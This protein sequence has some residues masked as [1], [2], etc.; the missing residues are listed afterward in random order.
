MEE[1]ESTEAGAYPAARRGGPVIAAPIA[2][3]GAP[4]LGSTSEGVVDVA[5]PHWSDPPTGQVPRVLVDQ[6]APGADDP[7]GTLAWRELD[8]DWDQDEPLAVLDLRGVEPVRAHREPPAQPGRDW[9]TRDTATRDTATQGE[10]PWAAGAGAEAA[11]PA[12]PE[13]SAPAP[14]R[15]AAAAGDWRA[16]AGQGHLRVLGVVAEAPSPLR[17]T[18]SEAARSRGLPPEASPTDV[19]DVRDR[20]P[21]GRT[22]AGGVGRIGPTETPDPAR[23]GSLLG[24]GSGAE[25]RLVDE[26]VARPSGVTGSSSGRIGAVRVVAHSPRTPAAEPAAFPRAVGRETG[27]AED[28]RGPLA[29][30]GPDRSRVPA[31]DAVDPRRRGDS[32]PS[33][34]PVSRPEPPRPA[35][36]LPVASRSSASSPP[37]RNAEASAP[38]ARRAPGVD[39]LSDLARDRPG[40][41]PGAQ[42]GAQSDD[43]RRA[44]GVVGRFPAPAPGGEPTVGDRSAREA[45][46]D[47]PP[48]SEPGPRRDARREPDA[49]GG[50]ADPAF[51]EGGVAPPR[52]SE[53]WWRRP[54]ASRGAH[55]AGGSGVLATSGDFDVRDG[56]DPRHGPAWTSNPDESM[57]PGPG[58]GSDG[59]IGSG[60]DLEA[61]EGAAVGP[62]GP[63]SAP[64]RHRTAETPPAPARD[65]AREPGESGSRE[66]RDDS[67]DASESGAPGAGRNGPGAFDFPETVAEA[68]ESA[69]VGRP[70]HEEADAS[71]AGALGNGRNPDERVGTAGRTRPTVPRPPKGREV[72]GV[73]AS[74]SASRSTPQRKRVAWA[75]VT[76]VVLGGGALA[77]FAEGPLASTVLVA[78]VLVFAAGEFYAVLRRAGYRPAALVGLVGTAAAVVAGYLRGPSGLVAVATAVT[79]LSFLW[80]LFGVSKG[81]PGPNV[82]ATLLGFAWVGGLGAFAGMVLDPRAFPHDHGVAYLLGMVIAVVA[83]DVGAYALGAWLGRHRLAPTVSPHKTWEGLVGGSVASLVVGALVVPLVHPWTFG[84]AMTVAVAVVVLAPLGDLAESMVKRDLGVK[85]MGSILPGHGGFLDRVDG[86]LFVLPALYYVLVVMVGLH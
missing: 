49:S 74:T 9:A 46:V 48:G 80:Y 61:G 18:E 21:G 60:V 50:E 78:V 8:P 54:W 57:L 62:F 63:A 29:P 75:I 59:V 43:S 85:D 71:Q 31:P 16:A 33:G 34:P 81:R 2:G 41:V 25:R 4:P 20:R 65:V 3:D 17:E 69:K 47:Q 52:A 11:R 1:S 83:N 76:G 73:A 53:S 44:P 56:A 38:D 58:T 55:R 68:L 72:G 13:P 22:P 7:P 77:A 10:V 42:S 27:G 36:T 51:G 84:L 82:G 28:R 40:R 37:G 5:L 64:S 24:E 19:V 30:G 32:E 6:A 26:I 79:V 35:E 39:P 23:A 45:E 70:V 15:P 14:T 67:P 66:P 86:I 12:D